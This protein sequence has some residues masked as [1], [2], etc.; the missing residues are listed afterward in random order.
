MN[1]LKYFSTE[2]TNRAMWLAIESGDQDATR[3]LTIAYCERLQEAKLA[4]V[5]ARR[6]EKDK[7]RTSR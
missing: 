7:E 4:A 6:A 2:E 3:E 1:P 5:L